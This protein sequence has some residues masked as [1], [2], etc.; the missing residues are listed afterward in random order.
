MTLFVRLE[1]CIC[2]RRLTDLLHG[3]THSRGNF[4]FRESSWEIMGSFCKTLVV[5]CSI[6]K[7]GLCYHDSRAFTDAPVSEKVNNFIRKLI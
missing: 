6:K 5:E 1:L 3:T 4:T 2:L 7:L